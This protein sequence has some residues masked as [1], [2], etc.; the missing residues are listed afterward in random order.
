MRVL[1]LSLTNFRNYERVEVSFKPGVNL[2]LGRNGQGKTNLVEAIGFFAHLGSHRVSSNSAL[3]R[4]GQD[5]AIARMRVGVA[6]REVLL[7]LQINRDSPNR[8]QVN[9]NGVPPREIPRWM[10]AV[11]FA[12]E[13][14]SL[15]R[16]DPARRRQFLDEA[17][18]SLMPTTRTL[19]QDYERVV[20]QR[21][22]LLKS[23]RGVSSTRS[24]ES[25]LGIWDAQLV[26]LGSRVMIARRELVDS[27]CDPLAVSYQALVE[28]NHAPQLSLL[29]SVR[30][31]VAQRG[32][33]RETPEMDSPGLAEGG[34]GQERAGTL[35]VSRETLAEQFRQALDR[36]RPVEVERGV[37]LVGPH[38]DDLLMRL[39]DLPV[40]G[41]AS[42]GE[43]WSFVLSLKLALAEVM[44]AS[45]PSGD[46]VLMLDD[47]FAELDVERRNR[48]MQAVGQYEQVVITAA[49]EADIPAMSTWHRTHIEAGTARRWE[50]GVA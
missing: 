18:A 42:H 36:I 32:V 26:D 6:E 16:G 27:L 25:S 8:A 33:S 14:L 1:E 48:L 9:R 41:Y 4:S 38:R 28:S 37:T 31:T 49:V 23:M 11:L 7:E 3:I 30:T 21:T 13:D 20:R 12:P 45:L 46:P 22:A 5:A 24:L 19:F 34:D 29:E 35:D 40:K 39:N 44:R 43:S 15:V 10:S 17:V 47:V 50:A 2:F